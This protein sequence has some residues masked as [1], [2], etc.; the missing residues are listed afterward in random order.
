MA[1]I[2]PQ[3]KAIIDAITWWTWDRTD[4]DTADASTLVAWINETLAFAKQEIV[5]VWGRF[6]LDPNEINGI[7]DR[8][9]F[10]DTHSRDLWNSNAV[11]FSRRAWWFVFPYDVIIKSFR[12]WH[13]NSNAAAEAWGW[14]VFTQTKTTASNTVVDDVI[15]HEVNDNAWVWPRDY[16]N[17]LNQETNLDLSWYTTVIPAWTVIGMW[18]SA[19]TANTTNYYVEVQAWVLEFEKV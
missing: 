5:Q 11:A 3:L 18:V 4:L 13:R 9:S 7:W 17:N 6:L 16:S 10:E 1:N 15:L 12:W 8:W 19:P 14:V 2:D